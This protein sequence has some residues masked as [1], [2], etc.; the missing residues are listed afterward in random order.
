MVE[1]GEGVFTNTF[2]FKYT[3]SHRDDLADDGTPLPRSGKADDAAVLLEI[4]GV[5]P[6]A[7]GVN[8][9]LAG[10]PTI[11]LIE[12]PCD[13]GNLQCEF[14]SEM[15]PS[16]CFFSCSVSS[17]V[18][19]TGCLPEVASNADNNHVCHFENVVN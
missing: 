17:F 2:T 6:A 8:T 10:T 5:T 18:R 4:T 15:G 1:F 14:K 19:T 3:G 13:A 7:G 16:P 11:V 9:Y 12:A